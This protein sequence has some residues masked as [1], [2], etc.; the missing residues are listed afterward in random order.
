MNEALRV[1]GGSDAAPPGPRWSRRGGWRETRD[2]PSR[3]VIMTQIGLKFRSM[4]AARSGRPFPGVLPFANAEWN[5]EAARDIRSKRWEFR[6]GPGA[7]VKLMGP[8]SSPLMVTQSPS[9]RT[10]LSFN[11]SPFVANTCD[12]VGSGWLSL[13]RQVAF[14]HVCIRKRDGTTLDGEVGA[15]APQYDQEEPVRLPAEGRTALLRFIA[16]Q[17]GMSANAYK[18]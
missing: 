9:G 15:A 17:R 16:L 11:G 13:H 14:R 1:K 6:S 3:H 10:N 12:E 4:A 8:R 18:T 5:P 7:P 2:K